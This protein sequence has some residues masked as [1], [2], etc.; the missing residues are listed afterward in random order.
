MPSLH[1]LLPSV[2]V[3]FGTYTLLALVVVR[4]VAKGP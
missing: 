3:F 4:R 1:H 2:L